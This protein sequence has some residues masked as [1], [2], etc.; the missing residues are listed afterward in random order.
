M[1]ETIIINNNNPGGQVNIGKDNA[2][3]NASQT[4]INKDGKKVITNTTTK[5]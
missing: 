2:V 4:V 1:S 5:K 3:V